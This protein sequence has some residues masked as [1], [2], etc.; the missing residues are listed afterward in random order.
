M[1]CPPMGA[2]LLLV[3]VR[4]VLEEP[5]IQF[6]AKSIWEGKVICNSGTS[7]GRRHMREGSV[8]WGRRIE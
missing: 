6:M 5:K 1:Q 3:W 8:A 2:H 4:A 7:G